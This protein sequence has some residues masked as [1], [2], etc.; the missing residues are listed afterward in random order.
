MLLFFNILEPS[1][2]GVA[3]CYDN[4]QVLRQN[5]FDFSLHFIMQKSSF[6][7]DMEELI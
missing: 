5:C 2:N 1:N 4:S 6:I 7:V 3:D